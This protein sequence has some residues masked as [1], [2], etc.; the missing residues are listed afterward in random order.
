MDIWQAHYQDRNHDQ[1]CI[2]EGFYDTDDAG[3]S[4]KMCIGG[5]VFYSCGL[6]DWEPG[7]TDV[8]GPGR[9]GEQFALFRYGSREK[10][11][12]YMLQSYTLHIRIP[13]VLFSLEKQERMNAE[14]D[15]VFAGEEN[16]GQTGSFYMLD[17]ERIRPDR[18][19]CRTF[20]LSVGDER[21]EAAIPSTFF[22]ISLESICR[23]IKGKYYICNCFGCLYSDYSPYGQDNIG[24]IFCFADIAEAYLRVNGKYEE[25]LSEGECTIW[26]AFANGGRQCAE[27]GLCG[28]FAPRINC[29]GGYRG[30]IYT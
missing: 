5:V 13:T 14:L 12:H 9:A 4:F 25:Y 2:I 17:G 1:D 11:Y 6:D 23:Q 21:F 16:V 18:S 30:L 19:V 8:K 15:I 26:D 10:G 3:H 22:E 7:G 28:R 20:A 29:I 27:T 24:T